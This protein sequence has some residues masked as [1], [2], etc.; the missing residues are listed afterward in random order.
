M[1]CPASHEGPTGES[2]DATSVSQM[3]QAASIKPAV[4]EN[5]LGNMDAE[6]TPAKRRHD[7]VSAVSQ[8]HRLRQVEASL[9]ANGVKKKLRGELLDATMATAQSV[10]MGNEGVLPALSSGRKIVSLERNMPNSITG[11]TPAELFLKRQPREI[12]FA[13]E[14]KTSSIVD[15]TYRNE[16][17]GRE[18]QMEAGDAVFVKTTRGETLKW[19]EAVQAK[20]S[21]G[22]KDPWDDTAKPND[23]VEIEDKDAKKTCTLAEAKTGQQQV[24]F[25]SVMPTSSSAPT[26]RLHE[27][28]DQHQEKDQETGK[29]EPA[30]KNPPGRR[31]AFKS[32][33]GVQALSVVIDV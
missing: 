2:S 14:T 25:D 5:A 8:E 4:D 29:D 11:S 31:L 12:A 33:P 1:R 32:K 20:P 22:W 3:Q 13:F 26:K 30:P 28:S 9:E 16:G 17:P 7:D 23:S 24:T 19:E 15:A 18:P 10:E 27:E 21:D 6:T